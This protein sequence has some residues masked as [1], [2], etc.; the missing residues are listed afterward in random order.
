MLSNSPILS[1]E[2]AFRVFGVVASLACTSAIPTLETAA[3]GLEL[4]DIYIN[5]YNYSLIFR[6]WQV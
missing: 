3:E 4:A 2:S 6:L 1:K 5:I